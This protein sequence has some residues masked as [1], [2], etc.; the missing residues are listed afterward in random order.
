[1]FETI[2]PTQSVTKMFVEGQTQEIIY[3]TDKGIMFYQKSS[4]DEPMRI[5]D[6]KHLSTVIN[7]NT[8]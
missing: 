7:S 1:M 4:S 3:T 2:L 6:L 8:G 5:V